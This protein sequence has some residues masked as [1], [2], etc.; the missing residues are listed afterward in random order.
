MTPACAKHCPTASIQFGDLDE[1][2]A[3]AEAR[4]EKLHEA[5]MKEA[6][7]YGADKESQPGT[8]GLN[9]F[10]LLVDKPEVYNLPPDPVVPTKKGK[11]A[12]KSMGAAAA[13]VAIAAIGSVLFGRAGARS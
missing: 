10:F 4:V 2:R 12:W 13:G 5:G 9:A 7:L 6:Y 1:L 3:R 8:E 11:D